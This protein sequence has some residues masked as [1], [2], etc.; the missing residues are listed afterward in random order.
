M[1]VLTIDFE[2]RAATD[3]KMV[4]SYKYS[5]SSEV[6]CLSLRWHDGSLM[7]APGLLCPDWVPNADAVPEIVTRALKDG[8]MFEAHN[9]FFEIVHR[10]D[11]MKRGFHRYTIQ[12][13]LRHG[14]R[15]NSQ[16]YSKPHGQLHSRV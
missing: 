9:A 10:I 5:L 7:W 3:L 4:G 16:L 11:L 15:F 13:L 2:T 14:I 8:W 6:A 12:V 1:H